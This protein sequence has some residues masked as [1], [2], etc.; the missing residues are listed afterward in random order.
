MGYQ[1]RK[2]SNTSN[3]LLI[4][5]NSGQMVAM[6][7]PQDGSHHDLFEIEKTFKEMIDQLEAAGIDTRGIFLNVDAGFDYNE[8]RGICARIEYEKT[9]SSWMG[10]H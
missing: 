7:T 4:A 3:R 9:I 10:L 2:A 5:D 1:G 6:S 8:F